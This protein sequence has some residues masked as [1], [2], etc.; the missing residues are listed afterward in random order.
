MHGLFIRFMS[1][2]LIIG[3]NWF[4]P[5]VEVTGTSM[6]PMI[7]EGT[8]LT[9]VRKSEYKRGD[10]VVC[11]GKLDR[12]KLFVHCIIGLPGDA[13]KVRDSTVF[14][15]GSALS[16]PYI[17]SPPRYQV[18]SIRIPEGRFYALG[19]NRNNSADSHIWGSVPMDHIR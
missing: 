16:E 9:V 11:E 14:I 5:Q 15:N 1:L 10:V 2:M 13:V 4:A 12:T 8:N 18:E 7:K 17:S 3:C 19:D 6:E